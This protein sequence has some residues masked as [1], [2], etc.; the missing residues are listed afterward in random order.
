MDQRF[1]ILLVPQ[2]YGRVVF[3][4]QYLSIPNPCL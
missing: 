3:A 2:P 4:Q 1:A